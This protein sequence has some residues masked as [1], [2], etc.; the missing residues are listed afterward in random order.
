MIKSWFRVVVRFLIEVMDQT[1]LVQ[2]IFIMFNDLS[3]M[4]QNGQDPI[5]KMNDL[6]ITD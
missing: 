5:D 1:T 6:D 2:T 3:H 4:L